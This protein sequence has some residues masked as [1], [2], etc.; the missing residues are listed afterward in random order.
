MGKPFKMTKGVT[1][2]HSIYTSSAM[3][4]DSNSAVG[5]NQFPNGKI[6]GGQTVQAHTVF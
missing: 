5:I 4:D 3:D 6:L 2:L 1:V